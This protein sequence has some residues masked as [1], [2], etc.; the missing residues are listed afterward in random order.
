VNFNMSDMERPVEAQGSTPD[1]SERRK[2]GERE[3]P[4][5]AREKEKAGEAAPPQGKGGGKQTAEANN[6]V[7]ERISRRM[8]RILRYG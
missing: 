8:A 5:P 7:D 1:D 6:E 3:P 4:S 2:P